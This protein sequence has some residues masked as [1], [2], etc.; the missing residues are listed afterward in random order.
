MPKMSNIEILKQKEQPT[1]TIRTLAKV[2]ELPVLI[3]ESYGKIE[4]YLKELGELMTDVPFVAY[5]NLDMQNLDVEIGFPVSKEFPPKDNIKAGSIPEGRIIF[6]MYRGAYSEIEPVYNEM[7]KWIE[8][9]G[10][11][12]V[13]TSYEY[14]YN[15]QEF[16]ENEFLTKIVMPIK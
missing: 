14:Y 16:L 11:Q 8:D 3:G 9:N 10:Y 2:E 7:A 15:G 5:H 4:A 12:A 13:G 6:C 1:L